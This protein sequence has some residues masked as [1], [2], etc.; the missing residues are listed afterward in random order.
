MN[1]AEK[2]GFISC[3]GIFIMHFSR[4]YKH[5]G[6]HHVLLVM[7]NCHYFLDSFPDQLDHMQQTFT[8]G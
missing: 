4:V 8:M 5:P 2:S 7:A 3:A 1:E 6:N